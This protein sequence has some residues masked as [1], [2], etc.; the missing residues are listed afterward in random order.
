MNTRK[1]GRTVGPTTPPPAITSP[2]TAEKA[3]RK[4]NPISYG[5]R[6]GWDR[7]HCE[8]GALVSE[9]SHRPMDLREAVHSEPLIVNQEEANP[10]EGG[11][12][13][14]RGDADTGQG[15]RLLSWPL[16]G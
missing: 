12:I 11:A 5:L 7:E 6:P 4:P 2:S 8:A 1:T 10:G 14:G 9:T 16:F 13:F 3:K 15:G